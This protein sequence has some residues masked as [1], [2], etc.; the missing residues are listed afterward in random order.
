MHNLIQGPQNPAVRAVENVTRTRESFLTLFGE[1]QKVLSTMAA[2][3]LL[4][5]VYL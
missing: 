4:K 5:L 3:L 2:A 1:S